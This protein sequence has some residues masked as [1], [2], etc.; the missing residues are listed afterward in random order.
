MQHNRSTAIRPAVTTLGRVADFTSD[1][2]TALKYVILA[3]SATLTVVA[4]LAR[5]GHPLRLYAFVWAVATIGIGIAWGGLLNLPRWPRRQPSAS[6]RAINRRAAGI[7]IPAAVGLATVMA[8]AATK[9]AGLWLV[10]Y[11]A[12]YALV[13]LVA[14]YGARFIVHTF[15]QTAR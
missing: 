10:A 11:Y 3:G 7:L 5:T 14:A 4:Y 6:V 8:I 13:G 1:A 15:R 12:T 9:P 2:W